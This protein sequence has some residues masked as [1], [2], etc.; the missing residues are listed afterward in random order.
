MYPSLYRNCHP[1][2]LRTKVNIIE[3]YPSPLKTNNSTMVPNEKRNKNSEAAAFS[4][5]KD[6]FLISF[7]EINQLIQ[8]NKTILLNYPHETL[9][10]LKRDSQ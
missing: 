3:Y 10:F 6:V 8:A 5:G 7:K 2:V 1:K 4:L 9:I